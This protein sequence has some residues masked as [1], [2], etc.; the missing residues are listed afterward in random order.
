MPSWFPTFWLVIFI[1][2]ITSC[3]IY[4]S[5]STYCSCF[6]SC[7]CCYHLIY[8]TWWIYLTYCSIFHVAIFISIPC[9]GIYSKGKFRWII[10]WITCKCKYFSC[11]N[12]HYYHCT[13]CCFICFFKF[14]IS[15]LLYVIT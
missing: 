7:Y 14:S 3:I 5:S 2:C 15:N 10:I 6:K 12:I 8:R 4:F 1:V 11:F 9:F 13:A